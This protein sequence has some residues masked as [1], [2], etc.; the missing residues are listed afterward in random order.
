MITTY[1]VVQ[2]IHER[3]VNTCYS[4]AIEATHRALDEPAGVVGAV[5]RHFVLR[6]LSGCLQKK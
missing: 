2:T 6:D 3:W 5:Q 4:L 1:I